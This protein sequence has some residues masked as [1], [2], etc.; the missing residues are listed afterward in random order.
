MF[1]PML[2]RYPLSEGSVSDKRWASVKVTTVIHTLGGWWW[3]GGDGG[4]QTLAFGSVLL[5]GG[6]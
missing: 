4:E 3:G 5:D 6:V 2:P 1:E